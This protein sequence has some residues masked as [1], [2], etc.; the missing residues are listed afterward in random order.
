MFIHVLWSIALTPDFFF[1]RVNFR[2][3]LKHINSRW[4]PLTFQLL[5][6]PK[7]PSHITLGFWKYFAK[8]PYRSTTTVF[9]YISTLWLLSIQETQQIIPGSK[10][11][12]SLGD[13]HSKEMLKVTLNDILNEN[14]KNTSTVCRDGSTLIAMEF[15]RVWNL[16]KRAIYFL[17]NK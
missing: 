5:I 7:K 12:L 3:F 4:F 9:A 2:F 17:F 11:P 10:I 6:V 16:F 15:L 1:K 8:K 14:W 13:Q